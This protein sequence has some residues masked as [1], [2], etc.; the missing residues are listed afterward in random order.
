MI[1]DLF[2]G[3]GGAS[4]GMEMA[5]GRS[6]DMALNHDK[7]A[8]QM[9]EENHP[10]CWHIQEDVMDFDPDLFPVLTNPVEVMWMSP[11]CTHFSRA[12]GGKPV[13]KKVRSLAWAAIKWAR[14][15]KPAIIFLE[16]VPEF[17]SWGPLDK[18]NRPIP[19]KRGNIFKQWL[20]KLKGLGY[21]V[22]W[23]V[24]NC[25]DYGAPTS[26]TR[27]FL[28]ARSDG[29][30]IVW[31]EPTHGPG[32]LLPWRTAAEC[33]DWTIPAP[34]IFRRDEAGLRPL[35]EKTKQRIA[36][37]IM[38]HVVNDP[39]PY[40]AP[41]PGEMAGAFFVPRYGERPGQDPR[42]RDVRRPMPVIVPTQ[43]GAQLV[44]A[45]MAKHYGGMVGRSLETPVSTIK[46]RDSQGV[47]A[48]NLAPAGAAHGNAE[49]VTAFLMKFYSSGGQ[50]Q[51]ADLPMHT[52]TTKG[53]LALVAC[54]VGGAKY[55]ITDIGMRMLKPHELAM[56]QGFPPTYKF[57]GTATQKIAK[58]GN[59]VPPPVVEALVRAN[60]RGTPLE[61][62]EAA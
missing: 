32:R 53:R 34:S 48:A 21:E 28:I 56:A 37:G 17:L 50:L 58:I 41:I 61:L 52:I 51:R 60:V 33:I 15:K 36:H 31:P 24:L 22:D 14:V 40:I 57:L 27:L 46:G 6:P 49:L 18:T 47:V 8:L 26:R 25:A 3:A 29:Y 44:T 11:D 55:V 10:E 42:S 16:N 7:L 54:S 39:N 13:S 9:H 1:V 12:K 30:P 59:S 62:L 35:A 20:G 2:C 23:R 43:N 4:L 19:E 45:F 5:F 38:R